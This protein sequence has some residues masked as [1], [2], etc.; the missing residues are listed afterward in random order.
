MGY[1][2]CLT[3][4]SLYVGNGAGTPILGSPSPR[5]SPKSFNP[6]CQHTQHHDLLITKGM[7][8]GERQCQ[9]AEGMSLC[10]GSVAGA[11]PCGKCVCVCVFLFRLVFQS[12]RLGSDL[13]KIT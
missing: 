1:I 3:S 4:H 10:C 8:S 7:A 12:D 11:A 13:G 5:V 6:S 2:T 9:S